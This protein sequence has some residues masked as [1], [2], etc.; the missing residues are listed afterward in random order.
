MKCVCVSYFAAVSRSLGWRRN[1]S[2]DIE[3][4]FVVMVSSLSS[5][6]RNFCVPKPALA[7]STSTRGNSALTLSEKSLDRSVRA[8]VEVPHLEGV[9]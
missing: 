1:A 2:R 9:R 5:V 8:H 4:T 6:I 7:M 3:T